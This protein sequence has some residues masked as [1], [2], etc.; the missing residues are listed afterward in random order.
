MRQTT[1]TD[2]NTYCSEGASDLQGIGKQT[3]ASHASNST[4]RFHGNQQ[5][6]MGKQSAY[7]GNQHVSM[8]TG[9]FI[10]IKVVLQ[11]STIM[12]HSSCGRCQ[13]TQESLQNHCMIGLP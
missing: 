5:V 8:G 13:M 12:R 4:A 2:A 3:V 11:S 10:K 6:C 7:I 1:T 9:K